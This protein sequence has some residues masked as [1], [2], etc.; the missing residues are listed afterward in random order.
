MCRSSTWKLLEI[1][2]RATHSIWQSIREFLFRIRTAVTPGKHTEKAWV[3]V[4]RLFFRPTGEKRQET[5]FCENLWRVLYTPT[6]V[7]L[8]VSRI[9]VHSIRQEPRTAMCDSQKVC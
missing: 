7:G 1:I 6:R 8:V 9:V 4:A 5:T 3:G 2:L